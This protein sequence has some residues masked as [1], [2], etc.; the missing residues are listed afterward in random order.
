ML[1]FMAFLKKTNQNG[2]FLEF[3]GS[4]ALRGLTIKAKIKQIN[5]R[6]FQRKK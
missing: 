1:E 6:E 4:A 3:Q 5:K 2:E